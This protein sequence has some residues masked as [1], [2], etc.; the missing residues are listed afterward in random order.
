MKMKVA[1]TRTSMPNNTED[2]D[3]E[4]HGWKA[5]RAPTNANAL[6]DGTPWPLNRE[7]HELVEKKRDD[8]GKHVAPQTK[9][10]ERVFRLNQIRV[11]VFFAKSRERSCG[12]A[13]RRAS[14]V[15]PSLSPHCPSYP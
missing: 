11:A 10:L 8:D 9:H 4:L 12:P 5:P 3:R 13:S 14:A 7:A 2:L 6:G 15:R 1:W